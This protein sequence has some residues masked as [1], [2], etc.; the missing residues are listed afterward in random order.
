VNTGSIGGRQ[1]RQASRRRSSA[2]ES[3]TSTPRAV[4]TTAPEPVLAIRKT[5]AGD[6]QERQ[7]DHGQGDVPVPGRILADLIVVQPDLALGLLEGLL[8][9]PPPARNLHQGD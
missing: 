8:D 4:T 1:A 5:G 7:R 3:A 2:T 9:P 6:G